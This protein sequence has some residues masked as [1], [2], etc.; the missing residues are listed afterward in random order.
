[1]NKRK[2]KENAYILAAYEEVTRDK[3]FDLK[4]KKK[5]KGNES[6]NNENI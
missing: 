5:K 1:M 2:R 4:A 6:P 3:V